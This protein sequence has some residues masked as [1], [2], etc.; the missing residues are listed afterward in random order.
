VRLSHDMKLINT[1]S[2]EF[3]ANGKESFVVVP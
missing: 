1:G 3:A 2:H